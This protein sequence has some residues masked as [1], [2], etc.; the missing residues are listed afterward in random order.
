MKKQQRAIDK[1]RREEKKEMYQCGVE[2]R[3]EERKQKKMVKELKKAKQDVPPKLLVPIPDPEKIW[4][5]EQEI[6][7]QLNDQRQEE[8]DDDEEE[9][10][11]TIDTT[12][13]SV[14]FSS[15]II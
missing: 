2:A 8:D 14:S 7:R 12:G 13:D 3:N 9:V 10:T 1:I 5:E 6:M 4:L 15:R 11:F